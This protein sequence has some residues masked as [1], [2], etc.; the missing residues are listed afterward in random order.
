M[1]AIIRGKK[2]LKDAEALKGTTAFTEKVTIVEDLTNARAK[3]LKYTNNLPQ[4]DFA[5]AREGSLICKTRNGKF[6]EVETPDD[7]FRLRVNDVKFEELYL[8]P[9]VGQAWSTLDWEQ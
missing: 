7:L 8:K 6:E 3:L 5:Y 1:Q 4:V 2:K 9:K